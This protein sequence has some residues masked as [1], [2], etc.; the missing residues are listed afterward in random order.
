MSQKWKGPR[1]TITARVSETLAGALRDRAS[2]LGIPVGDLVAIGMAEYMGMPEQ[3]PKQPD[4][5]RVELPIT[6]G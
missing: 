2:E 6:P 3:A 5:T 4:P 1:H